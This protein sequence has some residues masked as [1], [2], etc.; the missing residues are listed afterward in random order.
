[1]I[2][3]KS[4]GKEVVLALCYDKGE[5]MYRLVNIGD[6]SIAVQQYE[7]PDDAVSHL[8]KLEETGK[9]YKLEIYDEL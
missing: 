1:M 4:G 2:T 6:R 7:T 5:G 9:I 8:K 3:F